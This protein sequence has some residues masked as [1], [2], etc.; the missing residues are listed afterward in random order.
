MCGE[1]LVQS[2]ATHLTP[3]ETS[4]Y[5]VIRTL[6]FHFSAVGVPSPRQFKIEIESRGY[7]SMQI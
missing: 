4:H 3:G 5:M 6:K 1:L 2:G 7:Y